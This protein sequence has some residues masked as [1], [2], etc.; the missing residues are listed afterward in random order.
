MLA[1]Q[2][3]RGISNWSES[4]YRIFL[5][6]CLLGW[7][8]L[9]HGSGNDLNDLAGCIVTHNAF[10]EEAGIYFSLISFLL[11]LPVL[12]VQ[13]T[14]LRKSLLSI[15]LIYFTLRL[16]N[17]KGG[18]AVGM[19]GSMMMSVLLY[20]FVALWLRFRLFLYGVKWSRLVSLIGVIST[21]YVKANYY[22]FPVSSD[23]YALLKE[24][25]STGILKEIQGNWKGV[26]IVEVFRKDSVISYSDTMKDDK[27]WTI[28]DVQ[29]AV[30]DRKEKT[31][32]AI[33]DE[34]TRPVEISINKD[35]FM[36]TTSGKVLS[37]NIRRGYMSSF[38]LDIGKHGNRIVSMRSLFV[39]KHTADSLYLSLNIDSRIGHKELRLARIK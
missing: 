9:G 15:E 18:Y 33:Y 28:E 17:M 39:H 5:T 12:F 10:Y 19:G 34:I 13:N 8:C 24:R 29:K 26:E 14:F 32:I 37:F 20:D 30:A 3:L 38:E 6:H 1:A 31:T 27:E 11:V 36:L 4:K 7:I 35:T 21:L 22:A 2:K 16:I 25:I 23:V